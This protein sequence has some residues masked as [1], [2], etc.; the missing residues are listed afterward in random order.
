MKTLARLVNALAAFVVFT[1][2][3]PDALADGPFDDNGTLVGDADLEELRRWHTGLPAVAT[4]GQKFIGCSAA[5]NSSIDVFN[6]H[7]E[8][9]WTRPNN[10]GSCSHRCGASYH[11]VGF[12]S[13]HPT[14][15]RINFTIFCRCN[16]VVHWYDEYP[17]PEILYQTGIAD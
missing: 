6:E 11:V 13:R 12:W 3:T 14:P 7:F 8:I 4:A 9:C 5:R 17:V 1:A 10:F 16:Q 2:L 15:G